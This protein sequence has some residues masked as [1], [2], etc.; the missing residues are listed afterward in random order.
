[1]ALLLAQGRTNRQIAQTLVISERTAAV[2]VEH[3]LGKLDLHSRWQVA[4][5]VAALG[6]LA[7]PSS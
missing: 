2:H 1:M 3:I 6:L 4:E 7:P 5:A